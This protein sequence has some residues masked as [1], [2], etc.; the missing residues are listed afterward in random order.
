MKRIT[1]MLLL[2]A[3][4]AIVIPAARVWAQSPDPVIGTWTLNV[5]KS[6][7]STAVPK[8]EKRTYAGSGDTIS[9]TI[10]RVDS[11]GKPLHVEVTTK[12]DGKDYPITGN[13]DAD[14][15]ALTRVDTHTTRATLKKGGK[16]VMHSER[17]VS[18][19]GKTMTVRI[20]GTNSHGEK[21]DNMLVFEKQ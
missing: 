14:T 11:Q 19:D 4:L 10:D 13:P 5:E 16:A 21:V 7:F 18:R 2:G 3:V 12:Y 1:C 20:K 15:V 17:S 9:Q 6:K 8:S